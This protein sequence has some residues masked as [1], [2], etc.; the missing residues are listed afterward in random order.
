MTFEDIVAHVLTQGYGEYPAQQEHRQWGVRA[1]SKRLPEGTPCMC[2]DYK[3]SWHAN[4]W[5]R[6]DL[7]T[8]NKSKPSIEIS[9]FGEQQGETWFTLKAYSINTDNL[10]QSL[11]RAEQ[12]L[13]AAWQSVW[14]AGHAYEDTRNE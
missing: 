2:N 3:I 1:F 8:T 11:E 9:I 4:V 7:G 14:R 5:P 6:M 12:D 13:L 10:A